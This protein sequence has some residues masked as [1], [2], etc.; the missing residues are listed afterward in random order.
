MKIIKWKLKE[1]YDPDQVEHQS[2]YLFT[3]KQADKLTQIANKYFTRAT[4]WAEDAQAEHFR[5][6][7]L[8]EQP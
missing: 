4:H 2:P 8:A 5:E 1:A 3:P 6:L 7:S